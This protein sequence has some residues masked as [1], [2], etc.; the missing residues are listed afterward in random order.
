M[1][2]LALSEQP[3]G[4]PLCSPEPMAGASRLTPPPVKPARAQ[5][6]FKALG[7]GQALGS[8]RPMGEEGWGRCLVTGDLKVPQHPL[9][10]SA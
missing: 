9:L 3:A 10:P 1:T 4:R 6:D 7:A 8:V 5:P 2:S